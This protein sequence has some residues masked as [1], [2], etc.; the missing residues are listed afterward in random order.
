MKKVLLIAMLYMG[1]LGLFAQE[2]HKLIGKSEYVATYKLIFQTDTIKGRIIMDNIV[3]ARLSGPSAE[4]VLD[5]NKL[6]R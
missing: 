4:V 2:G 3:A 1:T 5:S 6:Y